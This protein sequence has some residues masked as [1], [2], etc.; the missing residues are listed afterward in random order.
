MKL[1]IK[2]SIPYSNS[3][4]STAMLL[5]KYQGSSKTQFYAARTYS[6]MT[7]SNGNISRVPGR[8]PGNYPH[9]GQWRGALMFSLICTW[10][11]VWVNNCEAGDL[12]R[13]RAHYDVIAMWR[14]TSFHPENSHL[15][16]CGNTCDYIT[17]RYFDIRVYGV[18]EIGDKRTVILFLKLCNEA[19]YTCVFQYPKFS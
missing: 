2:I 4:G 17:S 12:R 14:R 7:S 11:N 9:K 15:E 5:T 16:S 19:P 6:M 8:S 10:I 3:G 1:R 18:C 13:R